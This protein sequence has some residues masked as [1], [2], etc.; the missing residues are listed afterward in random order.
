MKAEDYFKI[1]KIEKDED[2]R[3]CFTDTLFLT[4]RR[5]AKQL[6]NTVKNY[7]F[8]PGDANSKKISIIYLFLQRFAVKGRTTKA[9]FMAWM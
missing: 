3:K 5:W 2:Q 1:Y 8:N 4:V 7:E 6:L 9:M